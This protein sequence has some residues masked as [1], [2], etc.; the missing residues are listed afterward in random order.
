MGWTFTE[1]RKGMTDRAFFEHEFPHMLGTYGHI[2]DCATIANVFYAAVQNNDDA[3][4]APGRTWGL[5]VLIQRNGSDRYNFGYK[6]MDEGMGPCEERCP[7]RIL[8]QL[9]DPAPN[10]YAE[11]W[12]ERCRKANAARQ[13]KGTIRV[14]QT[15]RFTQPE[16]LARL[17]PLTKVDARKGTF[18]NVHGTR[19]HISWWRKANWEPA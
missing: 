7:D 6:E 15:V 12:R 17:G 1:R 4:H 19:Y 11:H 8:D 3:P 2:V 16:N 14:G 9:T 5:V 18:T 13:A 10:E